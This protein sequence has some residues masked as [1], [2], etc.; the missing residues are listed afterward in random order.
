MKDEQNTEGYAKVDFIIGK[1]RSKVQYADVQTVSRM[2][3]HNYLSEIT[4][5]FHEIGSSLNEFYFAY[6]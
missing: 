1:V 6:S 5:D 3:L 2:G 4:A